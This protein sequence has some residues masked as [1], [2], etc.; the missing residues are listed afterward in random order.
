MDSV[1]AFADL[2]RGYERAFGQHRLDAEPGEDG[3]LEGKAKTVHE[4]LTKTAIE[5]HLSGKG[6]SLGIIPL[7]SDCTVWWGAIDLDIRGPQKLR[8]PVEAIER[9]IHGLGLPL[10]VCRSKSGGAHCYLFMAEAANPKLVQ[11]KLTEWAAALG[12][13][14]TE[15]FPKQTAR[16][17]DGDAGNWINM[18]YYDA[19]NTLRPCVVNN[20]SLSLEKFLEYAQ[21]RRITMTALRSIKIELSDAFSD[22][23]PCLQH[24]A[25]IGF[26]QGGRNNALFNVAVY[27]KRKNPDGW[28]DELY[29]FN[30]SNMNPPLEQAGVGMIIKGL[31]KKDYAFKCKE[32]PICNH[33]HKKECL[34][35]EYGIGHGRKDGAE[36]GIQLEG[37]T[38]S[39]AP[40]ST[41]WYAE[42][43]GERFS[44]TTDDL[45]DQRRLQKLVLEKF[46][47]V[48][49]PMKQEDWLD[50]VA[51]LL[52][53]VEVVEAPEDAS[54][55]GQFENLLDAFM[56]RGALARNRDEL[57]K[58]N[59]WLNP[60][61]QRI[62]FRSEDLFAHLQ[63]SR[64]S[65]DPHTVW[66][67]VK[68]RGGES[69]QLRVKGKKV[70]VWS[71][72]KPE[73]YEESAMDVP[74]MEQEF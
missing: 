6:A 17:E 7:T 30:Y 12:Y 58:G 60:E 18:P 53:N 14:G 2:F 43:Q 44:L 63:A 16:V 47:K 74:N 15:V 26:D 38:A 41:R 21:S 22:G 34:R 39:K 40:G 28:Q 49:H 20:Q 67:W 55:E 1:T 51:K 71:L 9:R 5:A 52:A 31:V 59:C 36:Y 61:D 66:S 25:T 45:L 10:V 4:P 68:A 65:A 56:T 13:G 27:L 57:I 69:S 8:E 3:K 46:Q 33:C 62:V 48:I 64:F 37:I 32:P 19:A 24:L 50:A 29:Q 11:S 73:F 42:F 35:R 23:P 70:R 54:T 72:P